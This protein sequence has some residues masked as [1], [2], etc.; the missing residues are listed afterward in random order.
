MLDH[1]TTFAHVEES[2]AAGYK[3]ILLDYCTRPFAENVEATRRVVEMAH[4]LGV[5]VESGL[6]V[7]GVA[8][9]T[10]AAGQD[11]TAGLTYPDEAVAFVEQTGIGA[12]AVSIG[13]AHGHYLRLPKLDFDRLGRLRSLLRVR[14]CVDG[15][16]S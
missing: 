13:N 6:G 8:S 1:G 9:K 14:F 11:P 5:T 3:S 15:G 4:P 2:L 12:L 7:I 10:V 16:R